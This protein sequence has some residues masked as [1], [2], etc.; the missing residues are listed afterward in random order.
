MVINLLEKLHNLK[1]I[2]KGIVVGVDTVN[3]S[4]PTKPSMSTE[5]IEEAMEDLYMDL[6]DAP[7]Q[8]YDN[9]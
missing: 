8:H 2:I 6:Q 7:G 3:Y 5:D 1:L 4:A 9:Q